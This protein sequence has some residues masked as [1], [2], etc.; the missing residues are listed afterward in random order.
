LGRKRI[1]V[2][3]VAHIGKEANNIEDEPLDGGIVQVFR[4]EEK[5]RRR[6]IEMRQCDAE[7]AGVDRKTF[8]RIKERIRGG[9]INI[10][11]PA[12]KRLTRALYTRLTG[13]PAS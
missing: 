13:Y 8:Q 6:I 3:E 5:E 1:H 11:T 2:S 12:L 7:K 4:D 10:D 9:E